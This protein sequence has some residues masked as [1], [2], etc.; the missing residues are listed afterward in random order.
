MKT[1]ALIFLTLTSVTS[2]AGKSERSGKL[3][4][5][6]FSAAPECNG[7][8][9]F[10]SEVRN[11]FIV[12]IDHLPK[13]LLIARAAEFYVDGGDNKKLYGY[14]SFLNSARRA[15]VLCGSS[16]VQNQERFSLSAPTLLDTRAKGTVEPSLWQFQLMTDGNKFSFWNL[17]SPSSQKMGDLD[18]WL[19]GGGAIYKIYQRSHTEY[20]LLLVKKES[21]STQYLSIRYDAVQSL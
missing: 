14:Q 4:L 8:P 16:N 18:Q 9:D 19:K 7:R 5:P 1:A 13:A 17:K 21:D 20:E 2:F 10:L 15:Q 12:T 3:L 11:E 6:Q